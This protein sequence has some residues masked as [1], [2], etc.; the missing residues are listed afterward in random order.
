MS[1]L[2]LP[3]IWKRWTQEDLECLS[4]DELEELWKCLHL[5]EM[6]ILERHEYETYFK[7]KGMR[8]SSSSVYNDEKKNNNKRIS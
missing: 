5:N 1:L 3:P 8:T 7:K 6:L 2:T 4:P